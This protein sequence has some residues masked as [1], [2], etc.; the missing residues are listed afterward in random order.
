MSIYSLLNGDVN[1]ER[2]FIINLGTLIFFGGGGIVYFFLK[3]NFG[4][5]KLIDDKTNIIYESKQKAFF[6]FFGSLVFVVNGIIM[7]AFNDYFDGYKMNPSIAIIIGVICIVVFGLLLLVSIKRLINPKRKLIEIT[8]TTLNIQ[9]GFL[10]NEIAVIP[11]DE[12]ISIKHGQISSNDIVAIYVSHPEKYINN[13]FLKNTTYK[14]TGTP[15]NINPISTNFSSDE[16]LKFLNK[17][18]NIEN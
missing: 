18:I 5:G 9:I 8:E 3:N 12:V 14:I 17:N 4:S 1:P 16:I 2:K 10:Q 7:I 13:G 15:I 11:K 6:S